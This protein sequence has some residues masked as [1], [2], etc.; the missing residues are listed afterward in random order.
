[1]RTPIAT[2]AL[3]LAA[4][5]C[6]SAPS[7]HGML[8]VDLPGPVTGPG[9]PQEQQLADVVR[10]AAAEEG[11]VCQP[12]AGGAELLRCTAATLG[13]RSHS[14]II[15]LTRAGTGYQVT[16][17]QGFHLGSGSPVCTVQRRVAGKIEG[18]LQGP[19]VRVDNRSDCKEK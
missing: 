9:S 8:R 4:A 1:M 13:N 3:L 16:I 15:G 2:A 14:I 6:A 19:T 10:D 11:L 7:P 18:E 12:G 17:D 5:G